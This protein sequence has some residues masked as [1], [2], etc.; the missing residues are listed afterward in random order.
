MLKLETLTEIDLEKWLITVHEKY[1]IEM[2]KASE[3]PKSFWASYSAFCNTSGGY[4][5]LGVEE[6]KPKNEIKGVGNPEK[7]VSSL[8]NLLSNLNKVNYRNVENEDVSSFVFDGKTVII[9]HIKEAPESK[10]PVYIDGKIENTY[11]RTGDG[12]RQATKEEIEAFIRNSQ[13]GWD[14]LPAEHFSI[15]DLDIDS[16]ITFKEKVSKRYPK[17][18]YIEMDHETFLTE[19]GACYRDRNTDML[20]L[21]KGTVLFLGKVN[22]IKELFPHYHVDYFNL[23]LVEK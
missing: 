10:K 22:A 6:G 12:D 14:T 9:V 5:I 16:L 23:R 11:I 20:K 17:R 13:P 4:I 19:I 7:T 1:Y 21:K 15:D 2:K 8:W 18:K 3:L